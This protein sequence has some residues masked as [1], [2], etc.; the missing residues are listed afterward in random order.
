MQTALTATATAPSV[1]RAPPTTQEDTA[2]GSALAA[3]LQAPSLREPTNLHMG[4]SAFLLHLL[5]ESPGT[6]SAISR[7]SSSIP[8]PE[9]EA[10]WEA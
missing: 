7:I 5:L 2:R 8:T 3:F 1:V 4:D 9:A 6:L 10:I